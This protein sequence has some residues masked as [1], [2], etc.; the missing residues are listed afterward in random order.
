MITQTARKLLMLVSTAWSGTSVGRE[1]RAAERVHGTPRPMRMLITCEAVA[2]AT[3][4]EPCPRLATAIAW[5]VSGTCAPTATTYIPMIAIGRWRSSPSRVN[6]AE[7]AVDMIASQR[8][9]MMSAIGYLSSSLPGS[10]SGH[11]R[12]IVAYSG[13]KNRS[14]GPGHFS[15][16]SSSS[17]SSSPPF[18]A[19]PSGFRVSVSEGFVPLQHLR[20][21]GAN[22]MT[23]R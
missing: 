23:R 15:S 5:K 12:L 17:S 8:K 6:A 14:R 1:V 2:E 13:L 11:V 18:S 21:P 16:S 4:I 20:T 9:A 10:H 19:S 22:T 3:A 7:R